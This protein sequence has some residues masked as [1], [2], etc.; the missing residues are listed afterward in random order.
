MVANIE[1]FLENGLALN[2]ARPNRFNVILS[3]PP[4]LNLDGIEVNG[5]EISRKLSFTCHASS[6]PAMKLGIVN[7][8]YFGRYIKL[9]G[10]RT[11]D[12][13]NISIMMDNDYATRNLFEKWSNFMNQV[14]KNTSLATE[15]NGSRQTY[16]GAFDIY[17]YDMFDNVIAHY[18]L[19][20]AWP[21]EISQ[22]EL[23][24][25][26]NNA[27]SE[28]NVTVAYDNCISEYL[29]N[30]ESQYIRKVGNLNQFA[31]KV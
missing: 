6:I 1:D 18:T 24:W 11:W 19:V 12:N 20:G 29:A 14:E 21:S 22:V 7:A 31:V 23:A 28:F 25:E 5:I 4:L 26:K 10:D 17:H 27:V 13:W 16:K 15:V 9:D 3:I 8:P 2:G 30:S